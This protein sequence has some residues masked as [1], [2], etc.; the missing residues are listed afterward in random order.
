MFRLNLKIALR[1]LWKNR[2]YT[3]I[4]IG[5]LAIALAAF[6]V[7][8]LYVG[9]ETSYDKDL[10]NYD[11]IYLVGRNLPD[12]KTDYTPA[13]LAKALKDHFPEIEMAGRTKSIPF[14]FPMTTDHGR[15]Y[16]K[17]ALQLDQQ[18]ARMFN[19]I[20]SSGPDEEEELKLNMYIPE[21]FKKQLF[22]DAKTTFPQFIMLGS[23][24]AAQKSVQKNLCFGK[25]LTSSGSNEK[26]A[27]VCMLGN[28]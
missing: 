3:A 2:V 4:N 16:T 6:I 22:P 10:K 13:P 25:Y 1:N 23:K 19:I 21:L 12:F 5:G 9:Y 8:I 18:T 20:P 24:A 17:K 11:R 28:E 15:V 7:V 26:T 14:E 27:I